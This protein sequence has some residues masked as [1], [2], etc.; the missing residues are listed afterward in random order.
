MKSMR[1]LGRVAIGVFL[2]TAIT[3][4]AAPLWGVFNGH[5]VRSTQ[6][7]WSFLNGNSVWLG[8]YSFDVGANCASLTVETLNDGHCGFGDVDLYLKFGGWPSFTS[9]TRRSAGNSYVERI[10]LLNPTP[11]RY[12]V[13][14]YAYRNYMACFR[15]TT[16]HQTTYDWRSDMLSRVNNY[17]RQYGRTALTTSSK[18]QTAAQNYAYDM[19]S[20]HYYGG[21]DHHGST[22]ANWTMSQ[23]IQ[24]TGYLGTGWRYYGFCENIAYGYTTVAAVMNAWWASAGH[25]ANILNANMR[26]AGFGYYGSTD[27]WGPRWVQDYGYVSY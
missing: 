17:R 4:T 19:A 9:Y 12:Y 15:I 3:A 2:L 14:L 23:R 1:G 20:K 25:Q 11:G 27:S 16:T 18:L 5:Y 13:K 8:G 7:R 24:A 6:G 21:A 22:A 10:Q 26:N